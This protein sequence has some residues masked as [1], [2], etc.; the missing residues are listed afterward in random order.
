FPAPSA[1]PFSLSAYLRPAR[2]STTTA[3]PRAEGARLAA[4]GRRL[5]LAAR[6]TP[7][8]IRARAPHLPALRNSALKP[9]HRGWRGAGDRG[10]TR[11]CDGRPRRPEATAARSC[12]SARL[13]HGLAESSLDGRD[14][15]ARTSKVCKSLPLCSQPPLLSLLEV[16]E[17][18]SAAMDPHQ[19]QGPTRGAGPR[20]RAWRPTASSFRACFSS[21]VTMMYDK[22]RNN[23][24][25]PSLSM[26]LMTTFLRYLAINH[27]ILFLL[28]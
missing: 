17:E 3:W 9:A 15:S 8:P 16:S 20:Q 13:P 28:M 12:S 14:S 2:C 1:L 21:T 11:P 4:L 10:G 18:K 6:T 26:F 27:L 24:H 25:Q 7:A 22:W 19:W 5:V 23:L